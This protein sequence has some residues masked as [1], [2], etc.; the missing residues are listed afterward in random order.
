MSVGSFS[1]FFSGLF[2][3]STPAPAPVTSGVVGGAVTLTDAQL[4]TA[5]VMLEQAGIVVAPKNKA[6]VMQIAQMLGL[7]GVPLDQSLLA[8]VLAAAPE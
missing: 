6:Q 7:L 2:G 1:S 4:K 5:L 8:T 3:S